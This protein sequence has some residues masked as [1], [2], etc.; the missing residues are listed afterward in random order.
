MLHCSQ[1]ELQ[2]YYGEYQNP[3]SEASIQKLPT[4]TKIQHPYLINVEQISGLAGGQ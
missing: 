1:A 3:V 2:D 4:T